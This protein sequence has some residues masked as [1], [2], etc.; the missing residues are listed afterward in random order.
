MS[1]IRLP[2]VLDAEGQPVTGPD[3]QRITVLQLLIPEGMLTAVCVLCD[4]LGCVTPD[5][6]AVAAEALMRGVRLLELLA[7]RK[8][9]GDERVTVLWNGGMPQPSGIVLA[10]APAPRPVPR[11]T[12]RPASIWTARTTVPASRSPPPSEPAVKG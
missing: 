4:Q 9:R 6:S 12:R 1:T 11:P 7:A 10:Q 8:A 2:L 3:G 5:G